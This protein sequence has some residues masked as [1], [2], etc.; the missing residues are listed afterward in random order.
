MDPRPTAMKGFRLGLATISLLGLSISASLAEE[1][2][3]PIPQQ[4]RIYPSAENRGQCPSE[5]KVITYPSPYQEGGFTASGLAQLSPIAGQAQFDTSDLF[6]VTWRAR[7]KPEYRSCIATAGL[8]GENGGQDP[9][10]FRARFIGGNV[11]FIFDTTGF[12]D[13]NDQTL[14]ILRQNIEKGNPTWRFGG[15]D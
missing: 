1:T 12:A 11:Y 9:G 8:I 6:S 15:T 2:P 5:I 3:Q 10:M 13:A 4:L 14:V 7:L